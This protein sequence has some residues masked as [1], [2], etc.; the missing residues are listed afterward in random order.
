MLIVTRFFLKIKTD[1]GSPSTI[2]CEGVLFSTA[3]KINH[4][5]HTKLTAIV[6]SQVTKL[7]FFFFFFW[8]TSNNKHRTNSTTTTNTVPL[9]VK[10]YAISNI[11]RVRF[12]IFF[13]HRGS[14]T[15]APVS[16]NS[17]TFQIKPS[18][19]A[20]SIAMVYSYNGKPQSKLFKQ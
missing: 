14:F 20:T 17:P 18:H 15:N 4:K 9:R 2:V 16:R 12:C 3:H 6:P 5:H 10:R 13:F 19:I 8:R 1:T 7:N 11:S